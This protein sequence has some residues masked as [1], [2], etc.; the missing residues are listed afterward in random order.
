MLTS[1]VLCCCVPL[2]ENIQTLSSLP[3]SPIDALGAE[4]CLR[5]Q[6]VRVALRPV[7]FLVVICKEKC[8]L[9]T[10]EDEYDE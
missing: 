1:Q 2:I 6:G 5:Q 7:R 4:P 9:A 3:S 10:L 8:A